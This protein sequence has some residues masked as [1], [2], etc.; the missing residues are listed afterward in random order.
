[1]RKESTAS[2]IRR[3]MAY[4][5]YY[6]ISEYARLVKLSKQS[7]SQKVQKRQLVFRIENNRP[8]V[9]YDNGEQAAIKYGKKIDLVS[10]F[11]SVGF[12]NRSKSFLINDHAVCDIKQLDDNSIRIQFY[13]ENKNIYLIVKKEDII[14]D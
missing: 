5:G 11:H 4:E 9:K 7:I 13:G 14:I 2:L 1:M 3:K 8:Y 6:E 12:T 10:I